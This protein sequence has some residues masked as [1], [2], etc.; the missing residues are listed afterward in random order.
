[1]EDIGIL[2]WQKIK[3]KAKKRSTKKI[4][5]AKKQIYIFYSIKMSKNTLQFGDV[6]V[7]KKNLHAS[8]Q[9]IALNSVNINQIAVSDKFKHSGKCLKYFNGYKDTDNIRP[10]CVYAMFCF[11]RQDT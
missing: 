11:Q 5:S 9:P 7:Y 6:E 1:M 4:L 8:K 3:K 2:T 10:L